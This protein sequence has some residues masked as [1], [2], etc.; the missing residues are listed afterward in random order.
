[1]LRKLQMKEA[2]LVKFQREA[3]T[4]LSHLCDESVGVWS[5]GAEESAVVK[6]RPASLMKRL[7][8]SVSSGSA[9]R[10]CGPEAAKAGCS[11]CWQLNLVTQV[12]LVLKAGRGHG[13][14]L[15]LVTV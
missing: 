2:W 3:K 13:E 12:V 7:L 4:L 11:L 15:R 1:M 14:Q 6:K 5:A 10:S 8:G 9:H